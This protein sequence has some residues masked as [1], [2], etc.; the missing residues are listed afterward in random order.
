MLQNMLGISIGTRSIGTAVIR[1][2]HL[3]DWQVKSYKGKMNQ[4][5]LHMISGSVLKLF[6]NYC[7]NEV[8][9]KVP[10]KAHT[11]G[12]IVLLK[13]HL[14]KYFNTRNIQIHYYT[15]SD[16]KA[17]LQVPVGNKQDLL[18]WAVERYIELQIVYRKE[19][20][21]KN[22]YYIKL[23]EAVAVLHIHIYKT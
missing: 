21:N 6:R 2:G 15:L 14:T 11:Y 5:K 1:K 16:I 19:M 8:V 13:K 22:S 9:I 4:Q 18:Q 17:S 12:N 20:S 10:D 7:C 3:L 23:F